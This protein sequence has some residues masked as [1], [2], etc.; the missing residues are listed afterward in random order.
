MTAS[1]QRPEEQAVQISVQLH[2]VRDASST[3]RTGA[4][5][6]LA[7]IGFTAVEFDDHQTTT[8]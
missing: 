3:D 5:R 8:L 7:E 6:S 2:S 1:T 4:L